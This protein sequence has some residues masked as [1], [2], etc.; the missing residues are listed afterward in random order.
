MTA[1][2][3]NVGADGEREFDID[4]AGFDTRAIRTQAHRSGHR[5]HSVPVYLTSS[6][7]FD[8]AEQGRDLFA[9][10]EEGLVYSRYGNPS[11]DEFVTKLCRMEGT[12]D[13]IATAT[14]MAAMFASIA[15][16]VSAGD[17]VVC[18]R[19]VFGSTSQILTKLLPRWNIETTFVAPGET[20][21]W[22]EAIRDNTRLLFAETPSN[23]GL[24][25]IDIEAVAEIARDAGA[26][27]VVDNCF[28]TP[29]LQQPA[30]LG[31][32][33][34]T[35]SATKF[36]D[37]Q[38]RVLGGAM[39]G[40]ADII[41]ELRFFTRQTGPALSPFNAWVLSKS[42]ETLSLR[43]D[44]H[45]ESAESIAR[46]LTTHKA[47]TRVRYPFLESHPQH[48]LARRQM[49]RGGGLVTI[50]VAGDEGAAMRFINRLRMVSRSS[51]LGDSRSIATHP[52]TTTHA[53][54]SE[55]ERR[56]LGILPSTVRLAIGLEDVEDIF[57]D[58]DAALAAG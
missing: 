58:I 24:E 8:S 6:F 52:R 57:A 32:D 15:G 17:H 7:V 13:G 25:L 29:W 43:V 18:S 42:L 5:E 22:R 10:T 28:A 55:D 31:A 27:F 11:V 53:K 34:V 4:A 3:G 51:N 46:R 20:E 16:L 23:P 26:L 41:D 37:G 38:G 50:D 47:V 36:M 40:P 9:G 30:R 56:A 45:C 21:A 2:R 19:A 54:L 39:L 44:R 48:E 14:G 49:R 35:H 12:E 1:K 33:I